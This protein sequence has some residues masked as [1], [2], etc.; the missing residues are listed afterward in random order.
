MQQHQSLDLNQ[1]NFRRLRFYTRTLST[2]QITLKMAVFEKAIFFVFF[3]QALSWRFCDGTI[4]DYIK[5]CKRDP[6]TISD[7]VKNSIELLRPKLTEGIPELKVPSIEPFVIP[8]LVVDQGNVIRFKAVGRDV[9]VTGASNFKL[10]SLH[11]D[12]DSLQIKGRVYFPRLEFDGKYDLDARLLAIPVH[13]K[14]HIE[15]N[16]TKCFAEILLQGKLEEKN[17]KEYLK[18]SS[19]TTDIEVQDYSLHITNLFNGDQQLDSIANEVLNQNKGEFLRASKPFIERTC[20]NLFKKI[21][22]RISGS[23]PLDELLPFP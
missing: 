18:F 22:N 16:A 13:G 21:A 7:C 4:P 1:F 8:E 17:G 20:S 3:L 5:V 15:T 10:K 11:V 23:F 12:L 9:K 2:K 14:G 19:V 6:D